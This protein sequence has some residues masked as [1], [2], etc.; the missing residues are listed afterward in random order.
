MFFN[1]KNKKKFKLAIVASILS[2]AI[3]GCNIQ[4]NNPF[5]PKA[6]LSVTGIKAGAAVG[7]DAA[8]TSTAVKG[9][10]IFQSFKTAENGSIIASY[11]L[12]DPEVTIENRQGL[13]RVIFKQLIV[14]HTIKGKKLPATVYPISITIPSGGTFKGS[15]PVISNSEDI[16]SIIYPN[17]TF[18]E[19]Y[20]GFSEGT[21]LGLDDNGYL[22]TLKFST[23]T[24]FETDPSGIKVVATSSPSPSATPSPATAG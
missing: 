13:P 2:F 17:N 22:I 11:N 3:Y 16:K 24:K 5:M 21:L 18:A 19:V 4:F 7:G 15:I 6:E 1:S 10:G 23:P 8:S 9:V 14:E 20:S 12:V